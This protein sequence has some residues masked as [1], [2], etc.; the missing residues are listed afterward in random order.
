MRATDPSSPAGAERDR[1]SRPQTWPMTS[2]IT[3]ETPIVS[4]TWSRCRPRRRQKQ[5]LEDEAKQAER[6][7]RREHREPERAGGLD[8][9]ERDVRTQ[10][11][12]RP[13]RE[14]YDIHHPEHEG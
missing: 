9:R 14:V 4:R 13:V 6:E 5:G 2:T 12:E 1:T 8:D 7:R 10:H 3:S 11:V